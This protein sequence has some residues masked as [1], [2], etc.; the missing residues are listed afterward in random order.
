LL[1]DA[2]DKMGRRR[3]HYNEERPHSAIENIL[4]IRLANPTGDTSPPDSS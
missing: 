4:P 2:R 3:T 1:E